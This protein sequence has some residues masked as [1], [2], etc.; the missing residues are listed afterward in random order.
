MK[1]IISLLISLI[2][3]MG[4]VFSLTSCYISTAPKVPDGYKV[5]ENFGISF[6]YPD[7]WSKEGDIATMLMNPA[8]IGNNI[9]VLF[10]P[11]NDIYNNLTLES[12]NK[13]IRPS[14]EANGIIPLN[15]SIS[16]G[17]TNNISYVMICYDTSVSGIDMQQTQIITTQGIF[18]HIVT[19]TEVT[20]DPALTETV[21]STLYARHLL[22]II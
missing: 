7:D 9:V 15:V 2:L 19:I 17:T 14:Y 16:E 1:R 21:I 4:C 6:A 11:K 10:E 13:K 12:F 8:G 5:Y 20:D 18:T 22:P 3:L